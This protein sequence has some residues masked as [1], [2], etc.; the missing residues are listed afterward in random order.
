M[1]IISF[2][3]QKGG[4]GKTTTAVCLAA[5]LSSKN[6]KVL[7]IDLDGQ[8][9][10]SASLGINN[11]EVTSY[12]VFKGED[13]VITPINENLFLLPSSLNVNSL[14]L[15]LNEV[16]KEQILGEILE[17]I[18]EQFD[19]ILLDCSPNLGLISINA[20]VASNYYI[21]PLL[22]HHLSVQ[23]VSKLL[24]VAEK[25]KR[26]INPQLEL[27]GFVLSQFST[28]KVLHQ[29]TAEVIQ[30]HFGNK[31]FD[32]VIR[33]N[34]SLAEAPSFGKSIFEYAPKS[35]GAIDYMNLSK[36]LI[37]KLNK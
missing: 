33:E 31:L 20:L 27:G 22:P 32:T 23:G 7:L 3:N 35:N 1:A 11:A 2:I 17:P 14:E 28:R 12:S 5:A 8:C 18:K 34:I 36:E 19:F 25:V 30:S 4:V 9:N 24:E 10:A 16:G 13:I 15:E 6:F 29:N 37:N 26:R 21:V